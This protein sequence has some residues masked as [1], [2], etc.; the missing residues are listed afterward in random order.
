MADASKKQT[1][2]SVWYQRLRALRQL[3]GYASKK[4]TLESVWYTHDPAAHIN[5]RPS[6]SK[7]Q[8][9]ESVWYA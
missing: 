1:L 6:A 7:K 2:E 3:G 5:P 8:T 4:Q 9:L